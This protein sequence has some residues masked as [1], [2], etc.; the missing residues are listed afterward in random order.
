MS[1]Y[2]NINVDLLNAINAPPK[3]VLE[4]GCGEGWFGKKVKELY[5]DC[6]YHGVELFP[7]AAKV[8]DNNIDGVLIGNIE[9]QQVMDA[10]QSGYD[11]LVFG[12]VLEHLIDPWATLKLLRSKAADQSTC[13]ACIP[14]VA[15]WS[16]IARLLA[17][18]EAGTFDLAFID[19]DKSGYDAYY[20]G[21][22]K[23]LHPGG[24]VLVDNTLW[25][26]DV[27]DPAKQDADTTAIRTLN[28]KIL[29]DD[30][31]EICLVPIC[32]G[33]TMARKT[34]VP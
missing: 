14:N 10:V 13:V 23:L 34:D 5:P 30:R 24:L 6:T 16:M 1:Y 12:D 27:A 3:K 22:L 11:L 25:D 31:V 29:A 19:A 28:A 32:D 8:A 17:G 7:D 21:A 26:G 2:S 4:I 20:E 18:G 9:E 33:L 15:H